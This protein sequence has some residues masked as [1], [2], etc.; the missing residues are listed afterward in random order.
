MSSN[1]TNQ[2]E[3]A[4]LN[5]QVYK[6]VVVHPVILLS[7]VDHYNRLAKQT[8]RR[9]V[10]VLLGEY[11]GDKVEVTNCYAIPFEEDPK[12]KKVWFVDHIYNENMFEMHQKINYKE[13]IVGW[14][15]SGPRIRPHDI[16]INDVF[17][18]YTNNPIFCIIDVHE[19][20]ES[21]GIPAEAYTMKEE[22]D[23]DGQLI[24]TF[25]KIPTVIRAS[26]PEQIGVEY[27]LRDIQDHSKSKLVKIAKDKI[28]SM[29]ALIQRLAEIKKYLQNVLGK[30]LQPNPVVISNIQELFNYLPNYETEEMI[31]VLSANG[32]DN[33]L[34]LYLSWMVKTT[35]SLHK[36]IDNK[37]MVK[38]TDKLKDEK[39]EEERKIKLKEK[40]EK[41]EKL[42][43][44]DK[45]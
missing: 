17:R 42:E 13:I 11:V 33:Y 27:L 1:E 44:T 16:E 25:E 3:V 18:K 2:I 40:V 7:V 26:L 6:E 15:S 4:D 19:K 37:I 34:M 36:L 31:K 30:K 21:L 20:S 12:D 29:K 38:E 24:K 10:G 41:N 23:I 45:K 28:V 32:N 39:K 5:I 8:S 22:V 9:V 43:K 14:Y 35:M